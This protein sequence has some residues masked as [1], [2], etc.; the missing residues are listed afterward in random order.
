[1]PHD[2]ADDEIVIRAV[3]SWHVRNG[4]LLGNLFRHPDDQVSV[5]RRRWI[6]PWLAK[7][8]AKARIENS[9]LTPP[10]LY[11]GLAF[12]SA[13]VVRSKGSDVVDSRSEYLGHADIRNQVAGQQIGEA[14]PAQVAKIVNKRAKDIADASNYVPDPK[15]R[16]VICGGGF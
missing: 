14:L 5:S 16:G 2:V 1:V 6:S 7:F 10:K 11:T 8:V 15:P 9:Q 4:K 3:T 12:V 13:A